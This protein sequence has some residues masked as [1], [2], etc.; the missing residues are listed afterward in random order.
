MKM[1]A[2]I[3]QRIV[4]N[5]LLSLFIYTL[6]ILLMFL[7]FYFNGQQ[8]WKKKTKQEVKTTLNSNNS[9]L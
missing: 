6:P 3:A 5:A 2:K 9:K 4:K 7:T 1:E 8:P